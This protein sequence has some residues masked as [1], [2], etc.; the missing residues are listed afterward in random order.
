VD[1]NPVETG[2]GQRLD[3]VLEDYRSGKVSAGDLD[4]PSV[5]FESSGSQ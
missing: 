4:E 5:E 1:T 2:D 3:G